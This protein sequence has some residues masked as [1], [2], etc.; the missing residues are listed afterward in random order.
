MVAM[1]QVNDRFGKST[2]LLGS[3]G[4]EQGADTLGMKQVRCSPMYTTDW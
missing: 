1:D 4:V 3:S 2:L